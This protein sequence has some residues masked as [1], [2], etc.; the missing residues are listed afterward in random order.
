MKKAW[1][2][3]NGFTIIELIVAIVVIGIIASIMIVSYT[4]V[5]QRARD[6]ERG[7]HVTELK[8]ALEK[9]RAE[10]GSYPGVCPGGDGSGCAVSE[11]TAALQPYTNTIPHDPRFTAD[12][13]EDYRYVRGAVETGSYA[14]RINYEARAICKT[15]TNVALGW[16]TS[17]LPIC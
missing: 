9:Y 11:L 8:I 6:S 13:P 14:I 7:S 16:W 2:A 1:A 10:N 4:G 15:G 17:A 3:K 5:Q 12:S